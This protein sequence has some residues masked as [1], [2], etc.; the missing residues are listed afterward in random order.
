MVLLGLCI[1]VSEGV[2]SL[3]EVFGKA[4]RDRLIVPWE[5]YEA[6]D[7]FFLFFFSLCSVLHPI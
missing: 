7:F 4:R 6:S 5:A 3:R 2:T 1:C